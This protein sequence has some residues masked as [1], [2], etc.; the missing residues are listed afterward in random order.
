[1]RWILAMLAVTA[2]R[3]EESCIDGECP[4]P[5][6]RLAFVCEP[7]DLKELYVGPVGDAP[8]EYRL[9][10]GNAADDDTLISNGIVTAVISALDHPN[11]LGPTGG[12]L[13]DYGPAGGVDD[14][15]ISYQLAGILPEDAFAYRTVEIET[16]DDRVAVTL[17]G[18]LDG[19]P[20]VAIA[21]RY[22]L[23]SC[24]PGL[25]IR[26]E[27]WNGSAE[28]HAWFVADAVHHGTR[29]VQPFSP[30][31]ERG[32]LAPKLDLLEL[33]DLW[34]PHRFDAGA[35]PNRESPGYATVACNEEAL[36]GVDDPEIAA[37]GTP[38]EIVGPGATVGFERFV[39][40]A[41]AGQGP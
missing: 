19:R 10:R 17:R 6:A 27:L 40:A 2:C 14:L 32:Y 11:D 38:I 37:A 16:I 18:T 29:R 26:S 24:D 7:R 15:T 20:E 4:S 21:T 12:N 3:R 13:I 30:G 9:L 1:M 34:Q 23:G 28:T 31:A 5:C 39:I 35:T 25:R 8:A 41:G 36:F 22:E 33:T